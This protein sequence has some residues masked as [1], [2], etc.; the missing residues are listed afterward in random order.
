MKNK[1]LLSPRQIILRHEATDLLSRERG[2]TFRK[3]KTYLQKVK[4]S[5]SRSNSLA[6]ENQDV[7]YPKA[8]S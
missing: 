6:S 2:P 8:R 4:S 7:L 5:A 3:Q 1:G